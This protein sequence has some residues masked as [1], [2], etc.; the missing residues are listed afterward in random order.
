MSYLGAPERRR[1]QNGERN[2]G[3]LRRGLYAPHLHP[4]HGSD[5]GAGGGDDGKPHGT[6]DVAPSEAG[7]L[8]KWT[9][10]SAPVPHTYG[11]ESYSRIL[12]GCADTTLSGISIFS[13]IVGCYSFGSQPKSSYRKKLRA[14]DMPYPISPVLS[15]IALSLS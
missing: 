13:E 12:S 1:H 6:S 3:A 2:A 4:R 5:A 11:F 7:E 8:C 10:H 15:A 9:L 14:S